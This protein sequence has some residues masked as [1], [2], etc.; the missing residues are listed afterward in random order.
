MKTPTF[1]EFMTLDRDGI[2]PFY[3]VLQEINLDE[4]SLDR[5]M[6]GW[7]DLRKLV[8][9]RYARLSL[10]TE[11]DTTDEEAEKQYHDFLG[12]IYPSIRVADQKLKEKLLASEL[13]PVGMK[14]ILKKMR[15]EADFF[16]EENLPLMTEESKLGTQYSKILGAQTIDW[17]GE[18]LT[19]T[20]VK[21]KMQSPDRAKRKKLWELM[22]QSQLDDRDEINQLWGKFM[23]IRAELANNAGYSDYRSFRWLQRLRLDYTPEDSKEFI[24]AIKQVAVPAA[25]RVYERYK[26][27]LN[28]DKV[29]PWDLLNNQTT[30]SLPAIKAFETEEEFISRVGDIFN[31]LDPVLGGY[32][33]TMRE[34]QLFDLM[35]RKGKGPGGFCTTFATV[36]QPFIFMNATG[37]SADVR[38]LFH[39]SGHAFHDFEIFNL[40]YH[41]QWRTDMEF[42]EVASTAMELLSEPYL[43]KD[44]GGFMSTENA[45]RTRLL[46]LEEKL[47]FWPYMAVVVA[48]QH[49]VYENHKEGKN[50]AACDAKWSTL[51]DEYMPG[52]DWSG[53]EDVKMTGWHRKLHI[54][55]E[56]FYYIEYGLA[57]LGA[58]QI[59]QNARQDQAKAIQDYRRALALGGTVSLP[60]LYRASGA[61]L[62]FD[63][64]TL[65]D[66]VELIEENLANL[67]AKLA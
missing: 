21:S 57:A 45:A 42:A 49:W 16:C 53:Y 47:L 51:V 61:N 56:P 10:A 13:E 27:R 20:Q 64:Q 33:Q 36:G 22:S 44:M 37:K 58:F 62:S 12:N 23:D 29:R 67:E 65:G 52:I 25:T 3:Q 41:H 9:E 35:N 34:N 30:F 48:F 55:Q 40:P 31:R 15:T 66:V 43:A 17:E 28:I 6:E 8:D 11:L 7:S 54:H 14:L 60:E 39:E 19:L 4:G 63:A 50:P 18:E 5:W 59:M 2:E 24:E 26:T 32:Y 46:N 38:V 1:D